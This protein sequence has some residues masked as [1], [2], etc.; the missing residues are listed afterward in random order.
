MVNDDRWPIHNIPIWSDT[1]DFHSNSSRP[2]F[3][4]V[5]DDFSQ[6]RNKLNGTCSM[7]RYHP[8]VSH[9]TV[10]FY[11]PA[12]VVSFNWLHNYAHWQNE[13]LAVCYVSRVVCSKCRN[14]I[15]FPTSCR[16]RVTGGEHLLELLTSG[17]SF[18]FFL[19]CSKSVAAS[20]CR[21]TTDTEESF[22]R[23]WTHITWKLWSRS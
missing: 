18:F 14:C 9:P 22:S 12:S 7:S 8:A 2:V 21:L 4:K 15:P 11:K 3:S 20:G 19:H 10:V 16:E 23:N 1:P 17:F 6:L 5:N 13:N